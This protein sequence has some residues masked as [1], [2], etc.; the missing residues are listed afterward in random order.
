MQLSVPNQRLALPLRPTVT[1][2]H[3][4]RE[5]VSTGHPTPFRR[6]CRSEA[7]PLV[8]PRAYE[9]C[10]QGRRPDGSIRGASVV[11][12]GFLTIESLQ[13]SKIFQPSP[14]LRIVFDRFCGIDPKGEV[15]AQP[16]NSI[17]KDVVR[18]GVL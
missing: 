18:S 1:N 3:L 4:G 8:R 10:K 15:A 11:L 17:P 6:L 2:R 5:E 14:E 7:L 12:V 9:H 16:R 13:N